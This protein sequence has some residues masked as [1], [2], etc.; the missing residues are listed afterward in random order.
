[1]LE[2][3]DLALHQEERLLVRGLLGLQR[4]RRRRDS[5][6]QQ[7]RLELERGDHLGR[8]RLVHL[9]AAHP[10]AAHRAR[11]P[12]VGGPAEDGLEA[13]ADC[14][15]ILPR[16]ERPLHQLGVVPIAHELGLDTSAAPLGCPCSLP[17]LKSAARAPRIRPP[18]ERA[19][20][21]VDQLLEMR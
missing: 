15:G 10:P 12:I 4:R 5:R 20:G 9:P 3:A 13:A 1:V 8:D 11:A 17:R 14:V 19:V 2:H 18:L 7:R 21:V 16:L 6:A